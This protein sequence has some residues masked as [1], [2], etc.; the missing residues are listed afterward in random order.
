[1]AEQHAA[2]NGAPAAEQPPAPAAE[3]K[4][5]ERPRGFVM[6]SVAPTT[7]PRVDFS[8]KYDTTQL[9]GRSAFVT[10]GAHGI[11]RGCVEGLAEAG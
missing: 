4:Q 8:E 2:T 9:K 7:S 11:G 5:P 10:G 1:M 6:P 3:Q